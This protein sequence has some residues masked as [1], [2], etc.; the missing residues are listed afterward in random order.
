[1]PLNQLSYKTSGLSAVVWY[2][3]SVNLSDFPLNLSLQGDGGKVLERHDG[4][5]L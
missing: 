3:N 5:V 2:W 4:G 1:M